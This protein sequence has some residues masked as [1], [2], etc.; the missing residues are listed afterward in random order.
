MSSEAVSTVRCI[1]DLLNDGIEP[2]AL[3][4]QLATLITDILAGTFVVSH[5]KLNKGFFFRQ[6]CKCEV[7]LFLENLDVAAA[8]PS[9]PTFLCFVLGHAIM[10]CN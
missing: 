4:S 3:V 1:R 6:T 2:L 7:F 8:L 10:G 9:F 5:E